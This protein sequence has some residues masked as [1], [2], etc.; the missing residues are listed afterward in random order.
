MTIRK[1][2]A[3][4]AEAI[5]PILMSV[6]KKLIYKFIGEND[7]PK[8]KGF[9]VHFLKKEHNQYS[10]QNCFVAESD[11]EIIGVV[12]LY[13]G[14]DLKKLRKPVL[15]NVDQIH[16]YG[17]HIEDE[18]QPGEYYID[19]ISVSRHE[20]GKGIGSMLL[21]HLIDTYVVKNNQTLGLLVDKNNP[22]AKK[23]YLKMGFEC[24]GTKVLLGNNLDHLQINGNQR[25]AVHP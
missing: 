23:L 4:D 19:T 5:A 18:T 20:R 9:L 16:P 17:F 3:D 13:N 22:K 21:Q 15:E 24:V 6:L 10:Y 7:Y 12:N 11:N 25:Y 14:S 8:A 2:T 1:A